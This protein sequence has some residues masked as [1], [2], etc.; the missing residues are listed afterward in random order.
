MAVTFATTSVAASQLI[1]LGTAN[2]ILSTGGSM[3]IS[4]WT[5]I[6]GTVPHGI[7]MFQRRDTASIGQG[8]IIRGDNGA[9]GRSMSVQIDG[10]VTNLS[11]LTTDNTIVFG[12]WQHWVF[13]WNGT[14]AALQAKFYVNGAEPAYL[15][16]T[17]G[18]T[19]VDNTGNVTIVGNDSAGVNPCYGRMDEIY[20][21]NSVISTASISILYNSR[22]KGIGLRLETANLVSYL[23]L[24]DVA[25]GVSGDG[26]TFRDRWGTNPGTGTNGTT[27]AGMLGVQYDKISYLLQNDKNR[28]ICRG[29]MGGGIS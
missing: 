5:L 28:G 27:D 25:N 21:W 29:V 18:N 26:A 10:V 4:W 7:R 2:D 1:N 12:S 23:P 22:I 3:S 24:D 13:T 8:I 20:F 9:N 6:T 14:T 11:H 16:T 15:N 19:I 17:D